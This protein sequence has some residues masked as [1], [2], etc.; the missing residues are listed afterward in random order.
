MLLAAG[1]SVAG[2][3]PLQ[4]FAVVAIYVLLM[5]LLIAPVVVYLVHGWH[6]RKQD[7]L[8]GFKPAAAVSYFKRFHASILDVNEG[9]AATKLEQFYTR[10]FGRRLFTL[11]LLLLL[12]VAGCLLLLVELTVMEWLAARD[13]SRGLLPQAVVLAVLGAYMWVVNDQVVRYGRDNIS[14]ADVYWEAFRFAIAVPIAYSFSLA[15]TDALA[16]PMAFLLGSF[17]TSTIMTVAQRVTAKY[18]H[19]TDAPDQKQSELQELPGIDTAVAERYIAEGITTINQLAYYDPVKLTIRTGLGFSFNLS[20]V[21]D[22][23]FWGYLQKKIA[24]AREFGVNGVSDCRDLYNDLEAEKT[25]GAGVPQ[26][27][28]K[29]VADMASKMGMTVEGMRNLIDQVA[30]DPF[31]E[32]Q[33]NCW[34]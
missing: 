19:L 14:P 3:S 33:W 25:A 10:Q 2:L 13:L 16:L 23:L 8:H 20:C 11:P 27:Y 29:I 17:P 7:I 31:T 4:N 6:S 32:F 12:G 22:A 26:P 34:N 5:V 18:V 9:N 28:H 24:I 15:F 1:D 21:G 30:L